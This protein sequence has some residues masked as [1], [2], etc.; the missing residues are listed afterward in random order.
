[1]LF[2]NYGGP[3]QW[4]RWYTNALHE[5]LEYMAKHNMGEWSKTIALKEMFL[6]YKYFESSVPRPHD[7]PWAQY[8]EVPDE[9]AAF[10]IMRWCY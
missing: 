4:S 1:M 5:R 8:V 9:E 7:P 3:T 6:P 2:T 10:F